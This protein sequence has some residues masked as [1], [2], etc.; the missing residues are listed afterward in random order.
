MNL[1]EKK[2]WYKFIIELNFVIWY[3]KVSFN[4][5]LIEKSIKPFLNSFEQWGELIKN[6]NIGISKSE[7]FFQDIE[8][9]LIYQDYENSELYIYNNIEKSLT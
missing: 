7:E 4:K 5:L 8:K 9:P 6:F 2:K 1:W 3:Y